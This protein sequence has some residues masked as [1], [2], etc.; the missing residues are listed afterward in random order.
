MPLFYLKSYKLTMFSVQ[1][2]KKF[3]MNVA[4]TVPAYYTRFSL[5]GSGTKLKLALL[6]GDE[7]EC[8]VEIWKKNTIK[9]RLI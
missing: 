3:A 9:I 5:F 4:P 8:L 6:C 7:L 2:N 1:K